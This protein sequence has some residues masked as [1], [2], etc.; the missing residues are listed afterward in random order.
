MT[1]YKIIFAETPAVNMVKK[2]DFFFQD[3]IRDTAITG[4]WIDKEYEINMQ[5]KSI[6]L[7]MKLVFTSNKGLIDVNITPNGNG[8]AKHAKVFNIAT[9]AFYASHV[10]FLKFRNNLVSWARVSQIKVSVG[11]DWEASPT[12]SF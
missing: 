7:K 12:L 2:E 6:K 3:F 11:R 8:T 1:C 5:I 10:K 9:C 4:S